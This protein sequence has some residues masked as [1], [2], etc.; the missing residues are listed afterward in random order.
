MNEFVR[1]KKAYI[2]AINYGLSTGVNYNFAKHGNDVLHKFCENYIDSS[3]C[4]SKSKN[5]MKHELELTKEILAKEIDSH[6][7]QN[8]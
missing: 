8:R 3:N 6:Y 7:S 5:Q 1:L 4:D 2:S